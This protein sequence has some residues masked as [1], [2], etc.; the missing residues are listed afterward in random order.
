MDF[1]G[2]YGTKICVVAATRAEAAD[3]ATAKAIASCRHDLQSNGFAYGMSNRQ[4]D[5]EKTIAQKAAVYRKEALAVAIQS[6]TGVVVLRTPSL[7]NVG[8]I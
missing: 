1:A 4:S 8:N 6:T 2:F 7:R 3:L 5:L